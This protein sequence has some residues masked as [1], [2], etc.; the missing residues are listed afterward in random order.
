MLR[1]TNIE[2]ELISDTDMNLFV[3]KSM[4]GGISYIAKTYSKANNKYMELYDDSKSSKYITYLKANNLYSWEMSRYLP[5]S[6]FKWLNKNETDGFNVN[7]VNEYNQH[8]Y[9]LEVDLEYPDK[10]HKLLNDYPLAPE[11]LKICCDM[12]SKYCTIL[13][14]SMA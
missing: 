1:I 11:N 3:E 2:L 12:L 10:L 8:E 5:Y 9:I 13:Q 4:R 7:L 14:T 6:E